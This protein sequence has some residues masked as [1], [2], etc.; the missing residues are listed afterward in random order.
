MQSLCLVD[1]I[2]S[3]WKSPCV[4]E[5]LRLG[6]SRASD[7]LIRYLHILKKK[8]APP[9]TEICREN[10]EI[11]CGCAPEPG[12]MEAPKSAS[13]KGAGLASSGGG[14]GGIF[15]SPELCGET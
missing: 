13:Q 9:S 10:G 1:R 15:G 5:F 3:G 14:A 4:F 2:W 7:C 8:T 6:Q 12:R 11:K